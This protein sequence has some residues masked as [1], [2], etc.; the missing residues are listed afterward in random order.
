VQ[1]KFGTLAKNTLKSTCV[2]NSGVKAVINLYVI[3]SP[4]DFF[5]E[6]ILGIKHSDHR[7]SSPL[8][9]VPLLCKLKQIFTD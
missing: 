7:A 3:S 5:M 4:A 8:I 9:K 1:C 6:A 2:S